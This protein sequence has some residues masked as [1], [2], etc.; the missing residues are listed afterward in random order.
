MFTTQR[1]KPVKIIENRIK[2]NA[3]QIEL[4][5]NYDTMKN[6]TKNNKIR[7]PRYQR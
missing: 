4:T 6:V 2:K 3:Q 1:Q 5:I 7:D